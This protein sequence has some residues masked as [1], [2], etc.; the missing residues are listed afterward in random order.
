MKHLNAKEELRNK[1]ATE[2]DIY[3]QKW[4]YTKL[5]VVKKL[6]VIF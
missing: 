1:T 6:L 5:K 3:D 4:K 2:N